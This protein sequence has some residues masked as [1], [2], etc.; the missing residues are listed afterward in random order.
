MCKLLG[1]LEQEPVTLVVQL[2]ADADKQPAE[3]AVE[4]ALLQSARA[5]T[6]SVFS[7]SFL[8]MTFSSGNGTGLS[9]VNAASTSVLPLLFQEVVLPARPLVGTPESGCGP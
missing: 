4:I 2:G 3:L 9:T 8:P 1:C 6:I 7:S 5:W